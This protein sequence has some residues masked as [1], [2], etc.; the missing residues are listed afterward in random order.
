[1]ARAMGLLL[2]ATGQVAALRDVLRA[3]GGQG[4]AIQDDAANRAGIGSG[5]GFQERGL[6]Y[7]I[8]A[9]DAGDFTDFG[10]K[11]RQLRLHP[12]RW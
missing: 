9:P 6:A 3:Q 7:A 10:H 8:G 5:E 4:F 11:R 2:L 1:M 12:V